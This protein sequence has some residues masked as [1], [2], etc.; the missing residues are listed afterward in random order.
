MKGTLYLNYYTNAKSTERFIQC[1]VSRTVPEGSKIE[2]NLEGLYPTKAMLD[3]FKDGVIGW[4]EFR[5]KYMT[6]LVESQESQNSISFLAGIL[7]SEL[8]ASIL[9][10]EK[11]MPCHRFILGQ[12]FFN[13]GFTVK[14]CIEGE[15]LDYKDG[16]YLNRA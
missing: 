10:W 11:L 6:H 15:V 3:D 4:D 9:C 1:R 7:N 16:E 8:D 12:L 13:M 14:K 2:Y 5:V